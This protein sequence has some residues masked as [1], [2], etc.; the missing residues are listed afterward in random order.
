MAFL[1][2]AGTYMPV[3]VCMCE[4]AR[5]RVEK[6]KKKK[7]KT[8]KYS[9]TRRADLSRWSKNT[10][11]AIQRTTGQDICHK[12]NIFLYDLSRWSKSTWGATPPACLIAPESPWGCHT[13]DNIICHTKDKIFVIQSVPDSARK[14]LE[15]A[16][17][18]TI[19]QYICHKDKIF[20]IQSVRDS[21]RKSLRLPYKGQ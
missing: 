6:K 14:V 10:W 7:D 18:R 16:I 12:D 13:Q 11:G 2:A 3:C 21:A 1:L 19:G 4:C 20:V 17:Q 5:A 8:K 15:A 9:T